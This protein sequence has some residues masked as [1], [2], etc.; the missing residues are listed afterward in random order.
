M[1]YPPLQHDYLMRQG[2][3]GAPTAQRATQKWVDDISRY[4][5]ANRQGR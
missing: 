3:T 4:L 5:E 2:L 1:G